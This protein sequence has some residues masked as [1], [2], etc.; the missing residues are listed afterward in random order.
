M[1]K[2]GQD[3]ST[4]PKSA[5]SGTSAG[6]KGVSEP[7]VPQV[8]HLHDLFEHDHASPV[9]TF[10]TRSR[11]D[12][13]MSYYD[14]VFTVACV[15]VPI[16]VIAARLFVVEARIGVAA[17]ASWRLARR[18]TLT[19]GHVSEAEEVLADLDSACRFVLK[20]Y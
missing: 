12:V 13:L 4:H 2:L 15:S 5:S 16:D 7:P 1:A 10:P 20:G 14:V 18:L 6:R 17:H 8:R 11:R 9:P 3:A 19:R